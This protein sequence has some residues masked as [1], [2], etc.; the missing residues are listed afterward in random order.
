MP[1][2]QASQ[3]VSQSDGFSCTV[4]ECWSR[5]TDCLDRMHGKGGERCELD[6]RSKLTPRHHHPLW[7][8]RLQQHRTTIFER[9]PHSRYLILIHR[10][11]SRTQRPVRPY[12]DV[13][14]PVRP[15]RAHRLCPLLNSSSKSY[16]PISAYGEGQP[17]VPSGPN[18][19]NSN[20]AASTKSGMG[21]GG[22]GS[23]Y[24]GKAMS[25]AQ[26]ETSELVTV[27]VLGAE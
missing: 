13:L 9:T 27:P 24:G 17:I 10:T 2:D 8:I 6:P 21:M 23:T 11:R 19:S 18:H 7:P 20:Y 4:A 16:R 1:N 25:A 22:G 15:V 5:L 12:H 26:L 3:S 14:A